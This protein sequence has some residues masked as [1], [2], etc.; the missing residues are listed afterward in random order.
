MILSTRLFNSE[1][2]GQTV[3]RFSLQSNHKDKLTPIDNLRVT[4]H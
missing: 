2:G 3:A 4:Q 1:Y